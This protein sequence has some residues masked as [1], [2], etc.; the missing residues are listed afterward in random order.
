M[1][2]IWQVVLLKREVNSVAHGLAKAAVLK[3]VI[4]HVWMEDISP[5]IYDIVL[6]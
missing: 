4:Y 6:L 3:Q 1:V 2:P 5:Y